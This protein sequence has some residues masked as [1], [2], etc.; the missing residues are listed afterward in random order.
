M[1]AAHGARTTP[2]ARVVATREPLA[3]PAA[4]ADPVGQVPGVD[5]PALTKGV[6]FGLAFS[7]PLWASVIWALRRLS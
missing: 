2:A 1:H 6:A 3:P 5:A 7:L 4:A